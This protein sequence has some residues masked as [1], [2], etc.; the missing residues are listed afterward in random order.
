MLGGD[1]GTGNSPFTPPEL[2]VEQAML[3]GMQSV[4]DR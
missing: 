4:G 3:G 1:Y 2:A